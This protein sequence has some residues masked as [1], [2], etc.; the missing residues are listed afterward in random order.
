M[1]TLKPFPADGDHIVADSTNPAIKLYGRRF[2][3]DQTQVEYLAEFLLVFSSPK[4]NPAEAQERLGDYSF[5]L[6]SSGTSGYW[7][8]NHIALK[9]FAFFPSSKLETRHTAH[10]DAYLEALDVLKDHVSGSGEKRE[11]TV[12]LL[13]SL[14]GGFVGVGKN[15]TWATYTF[16][17]VSKELLASELVWSHS[18]ALKDQIKSWSDCSSRKYFASDRHIFMARGGELLFLQLANLFA[19]PNNLDIKAILQAP[20]YHHLG[21]NHI[22]DLA[23][24]VENQLRE[25]LVEAVGTLSKIARLIEE[26][27]A[28]YRLDTQYSYSNLGWVPKASR[29]EALLFAQEIHNLCKATLSPLEK[30]DL[31]QTLCSLHVLRSLCFQACRLDNTEAATP[32]FVGGYAW[33][34]CDLEA[35][36]R[37]PIRLMAQVSFNHI[38]ALLY[39]V[40]RNKDLVDAGNS[41]SQKEADKNGFQIFRKIGKETGLVV[42][43]KG[44]GQRFVLTPELL[45]FLVAALVRP[46]ERIR[47]TE[48][49]RRAFAHYGLA[50]GGESLAVGLDWCG[51]AGGKKSYAVAADTDWI[52]EALQQGGFLVEL[53]DAVSIVYN[54]GELKD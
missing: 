50:L 35:E 13:Q 44:G 15:R 20:S 40:L 21:C 10:R 53:S 38:E 23:Q 8:E 30:L 25:L 45:R 2:Y 32:G 7:T 16:L 48:F 9:L 14:L 28:H 43:R 36:A 46:G 19:D 3:K 11:E 24:K 29:I 41:A 4:K 52:E 31:L 17:P 18:T 22:S 27:L 39:R 54:P 37:S 5:S 34:P 6:P 49:Y 12:R 1:D 51:T 42:P 47:L 26:S 33:I